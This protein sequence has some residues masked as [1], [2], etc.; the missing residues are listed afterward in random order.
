MATVR[1]EEDKH[2]AAQGAGLLASLLLWQAPIVDFLRESCRAG[3]ILQMRALNRPRSKVSVPIFP[4]TMQRRAE[5]VL[6][7]LGI[8]FD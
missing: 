3:S 1:E 7:L 4:G 6:R 8:S 2:R 5:E